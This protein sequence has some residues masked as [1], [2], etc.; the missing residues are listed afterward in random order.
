[1]RPSVVVDDNPIGIARETDMTPVAATGQ[2]PYPNGHNTSKDLE[3][4]N[5]TV[6]EGAPTVCL[7]QA[8]GPPFCGPPY[9][10]SLPHGTVIRHDRR[11]ARHQLGG[12]DR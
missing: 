3:Q 2:S 1:M 12:V 8:P 5:T 7:G 6:L 4:L 10:A 11:I 9:T